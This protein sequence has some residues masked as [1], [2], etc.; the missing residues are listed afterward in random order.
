MTVPAPHFLLFSESNRRVARSD[1]ATDAASRGRWRFVLEAVDGSTKFEAA[2]DEPQIPG[3]RLDLLAVV[4]GLE[5][6][7]QPSRVTVV[8]PSRYVTRGLRD[9]L[10]QWRESGWQWERFGKMTPISNS[11]LWRRVDQA[12]H[13][14]D[15]DVRSWRFEIADE[16]DTEPK[17]PPPQHTNRPR[18]AT[19]RVPISRRLQRFAD[20]LRRRAADLAAFWGRQDLPGT[21]G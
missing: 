7:D 5:A 17:S 16:S 21:A 6:L 10:E 9:C 2:D 14:H 13:Y 15:I 11:D 8:T 3:D 20:R 18:E 19:R 1:S 4:R 12:A